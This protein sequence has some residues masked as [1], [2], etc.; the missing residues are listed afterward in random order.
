MGPLSKE[1]NVQSISQSEKIF[2]KNKTLKPWERSKNK[3]QWACCQQKKMYKNQRLF[4]IL[5]EEIN[6]YSIYKASQMSKGQT[7]VCTQYKPIRNPWLHTQQISN[8]LRQNTLFAL[9]KYPSISSPFL[10]SIW[11]VLQPH[12]HLLKS[13]QSVL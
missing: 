3:T 10:L 12:H 8:I 1:C 13:Y 6:T 5:Y 11:N 4:Y 7:A 2:S 9:P